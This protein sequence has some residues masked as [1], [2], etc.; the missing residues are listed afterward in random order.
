MKFTCYNQFTI[1]KQMIKF[2]NK[3]KR[4]DGAKNK[5]KIRLIISF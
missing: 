3:I 1:L 2:A 5:N 4:H